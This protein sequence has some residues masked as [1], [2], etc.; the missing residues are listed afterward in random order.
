MLTVACRPTSASR[1]SCACTLP[2]SR[3]ATTDATGG[4]M[5][6]RA[7]RPTWASRPRVNASAGGI[8][9]DWW[10]TAW[11]ATPRASERD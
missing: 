1:I 2:R 11:A 3:S 4:S 9:P 10:A 5:L 7:R 6:A 8:L